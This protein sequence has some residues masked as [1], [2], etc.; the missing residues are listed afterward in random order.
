[1]TLIVGLRGI[2][3]S[4][5]AA[6]SR[7]TMSDGTYK[8]DFAKHVRYGRFSISV[9]AGHAGLAAYVS[10]EVLKKLKE[11]P[12]HNNVKHLF[13]T[14]LEQIAKE[15]VA[16]TGRYSGCVI[17][18]CGYDKTNKEEFDAARIGDILAA[19]AKR[20]GEDRIIN[21]SV[22]H[23][24]LRAIEGATASGSVGVGDIITIDSPRSE[25]VAYDI[26]TN[27]AGVSISKTQA[28]TFEALIYGAD[29][30]TNKLELSNDRIADIYF[31][32]V[33]GKDART[34]MQLDTIQFID[35]INQ[36]IQQRGYT[37]V[38]GGI[39]PFMVTSGMTAFMSGTVGKINLTTGETEIVNVIKV[40]DGRIHYQDADGQYKPYRTLSDINQEAGLASDLSI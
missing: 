1:M 19:E 37:N 18:L 32:D 12:T 20:Q 5:V 23:E 15:Y 39:V 16:K 27:S 4:Y 10:E 26:Q 11:E 17:M 25:L 22:D 14:E 8:D 29:T 28:A 6:D 34:I 9:A 31:R 24:I 40:I 30:V 13:D 3:K 21:L 33:N 7:V 38:G 36:T 2:G 35:F